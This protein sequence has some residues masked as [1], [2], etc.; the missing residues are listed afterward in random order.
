MFDSSEVRISEAASTSVSGRSLGKPPITVIALRVDPKYS[1]SRD[2][3]R[4]S[5]IALGPPPRNKTFLTF[6]TFDNNSR[7]RPTGLLLNIAS[8]TT[9]SHAPFSRAAMPSTRGRV[10]AQAEASEHE[11]VEEELQEGR[12]GLQFNETLSWRAGKPIAVADLLRRL[13]AL[14]QELRDMEQEEADRDSLLPVAKDLAAAG[15][16]NHKDKGVRAWTGCC[17]VDIFRLCAPDAPYTAAQLKVRYH[18]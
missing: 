2:A 18:R 9:T 8:P 14:S 1:F 4:P 5:C 16:L 3:S 6:W 13:Q 15:L 7:Y 10:S 17:V 11:E 12:K